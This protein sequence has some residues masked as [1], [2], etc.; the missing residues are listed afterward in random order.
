MIQVSAAGL[1][2]EETLELLPFPRGAP[3]TQC[4]C[5]DLPVFMKAHKG[6]MA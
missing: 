2:K 1:I 6:F 4:W 5:K 3:G